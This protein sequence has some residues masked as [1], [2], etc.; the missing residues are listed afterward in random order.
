MSNPDPFTNII[1]L[2]SNQTLSLRLLLK[3]PSDL[4]WTGSTK[5]NE[6]SDFD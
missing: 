3:N 5:D 4:D 1:L 2:L 6:E